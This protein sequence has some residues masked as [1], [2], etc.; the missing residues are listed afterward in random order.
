MT[1]LIPAP[2]DASWLQELRLK[3]LQI[4]CRVEAQLAVTLAETGMPLE[5]VREI[6]WLAEARRY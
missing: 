2:N 4:A 6:N 3:D 5:A 1:T